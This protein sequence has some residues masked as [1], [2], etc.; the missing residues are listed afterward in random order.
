[1][2][3][4]F[5]NSFTVG[6]SNILQNK[7]NTS[8][9]LL[10]TLLHYRVKHKSL[11]SAFALPVLDDKAVNSIIKYFKHL[12]KNI[13]LCLLITYYLVQQHVYQL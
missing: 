12:K 7:Y 5:E 6:N 8:R 3:S 1:M 2:L 9:D 11:K 13:L 10:K 4:D